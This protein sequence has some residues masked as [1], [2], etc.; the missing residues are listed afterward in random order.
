MGTPDSSRSPVQVRRRS[1]GADGVIP[2]LR[3]RSPVDAPT[4]GRQ[5]KTLEEILEE[6][7]PVVACSPSWS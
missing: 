6:L 1:C 7:N 2:A 3:P 4:N 5:F